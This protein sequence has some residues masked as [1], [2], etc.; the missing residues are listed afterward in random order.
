M[1]PH[2]NFST[3]LPVFTKLGVNVTSLENTVLPYIFFYS[4]NN[5]R[6]EARIY[7]VCALGGYVCW[8]FKLM[9]GNKS[10]KCVEFYYDIYFLWNVK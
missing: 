1:S 9:Y 3:S 10:H 4:C 7:E 8:C 6:S 2:L 5:D